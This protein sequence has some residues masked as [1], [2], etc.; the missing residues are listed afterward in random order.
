MPSGAAA[1]AVVMRTTRWGKTPTTFGPIGRVLAT[2]AVFV[3]LALMIV[4]GFAVTFSWGGAVVYAGIIVPWAMRD[5]WE[6]GRI[7]VAD[8]AAR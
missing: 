5:I 1:R 2:I 3:P 7:V 6:A 8:S 4:G